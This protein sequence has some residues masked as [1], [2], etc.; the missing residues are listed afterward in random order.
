MLNFNIHI[1]HICCQPGIVLGVVNQSDTSLLL[2][3]DLE[4]ETQEM[5]PVGGVVGAVVGRRARGGGAH[6]DSRSLSR[7]HLSE[8]C[9]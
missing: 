9:S 2:R 1:F 7:N 3:G 8:M 5:E 4:E 6:Q